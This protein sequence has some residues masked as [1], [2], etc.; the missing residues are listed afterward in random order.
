MKGRTKEDGKK[1]REIASVLPINAATA[2]A[3][4]ATLITA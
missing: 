3:W 1:T 2:K 4:R